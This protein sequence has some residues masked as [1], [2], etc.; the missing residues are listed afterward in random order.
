MFTYQ[1]DV[2]ATALSLQS[3]VGANERISFTLVSH[4]W[5]IHIARQLKMSFAYHSQLINQ[6]W[7]SVHQ[8][9][10]LLAKLTSRRKI[11]IKQLLDN[12]EFY[13]NGNV[14]HY[15]VWEDKIC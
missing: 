10:T 7:I 11:A 6:T 2:T 13:I 9:Q 1:S 14:S 5:F 8:A 15:A 4:I 3:S 12:F